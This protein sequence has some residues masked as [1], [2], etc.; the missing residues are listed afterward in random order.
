MDIK[1]FLSVLLGG[2]GYF[3]AVGIKDGRT[4]QKLYNTLEAVVGAVDNFSLEGYDTYFGV[5]TFVEGTSRKAENVR[6]VRSLFLDLD[7]G[8]GKPYS[9]QVEALSALRD[10]CREYKI[11][12]P[13]FTVNSGGGI[14][15]YWMLTEPQTRDAWIPIA[16]RLK[17]ACAKFGLLADPV[18]TS[19]VSRILRVPGT[20]NYKFNPPRLASII[21]ATDTVMS[22]ADF[23]AKLPQ[24]LT[25]V[26]PPREFSKTDRDDMQ[27]AL[28]NSNYTKKFSR[29]IIKTGGG[30]GCGHFKK[31]LETPNDVSYP[32]WLHLLS[33]AKHCEE[34]SNAVHLIS[35]G[36]DKYDAVETDKIAA[37]LEAPH[38]CITFEKDNPKGCEGCIHKGKIRSPIKLCMEVK[39]AKPEDNTVTVP[40]TAIYPHEGTYTVEDGDSDH[41]DVLLTPRV[42]TYQIPTYP[43]PYFR[44]ASGG[45]FMRVKD[46]DGNLDEVEIHKSDLYLTQRLRDPMLGPCYLFRHHTK[47]EGIHEFVVPSV[48]LSSKDEFR[49]EMGMND[50]FLLKPDALMHYISRWVA[51]L[52]ATQDEIKV[53]TQFGWTDD[54]KSFVIGD[55]EVFADKIIPNPPGGRTA[56]YFPHFRKKGTLEGWKEVTKFYNK[57]NFEEH[58]YMFGLSFASPLMEFVPNISGAIYHLSSAESGFGKTT[59]QWGGASVWGNHKKLVLKG[60]DTGNSVWNRAEIYKNIVLYIDELSNY[61][62]KDASDFAYAVTDGEQKNRQSNAGQNLERMRGVEWSLLVGTTGNNSLL[63]KMSEHRALPKG[64]AQRVMEARA[65]A[66][67]FTPEEAITAGAL[68]DNLANNYGHAG[69]V[70]MQHVIHNLD[71]VKKLLKTNIDYLIREAGLS[72]QNRFW[73]AKGGAVITG[74][75]IAKHLELIDWD[76]DVLLRWLVRKLRKLKSEMK[77]MDI[78]IGDLVGSFYS[79]NIRSILRIKSSDEKILDPAM[80]TLILPDASPLYR[81]VARHEYDLNK[82]YVLTKPFKDWLVKQGHHYTAIVDLIKTDMNGRTNKIRLGRGTKISLPPQHVLEMSWSYDAYVSLQQDKVDLV[83]VSDSGV[84]DD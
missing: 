72:P 38:L 66:L 8:V 11:P 51:E 17:A 15:V 62:A 34:G 83:S 63:E 78:D 47:R 13:S 76:I 77:D 44:G 5:S 81:L 64:E 25:P 43:F 16:E 19:D 21:R 32:E 27:V 30:V 6:T 69:D 65:R 28:G 56:Q 10:F 57:P 36:Y 24:T 35:Q 50:I 42:K 1:T 39:E 29:L 33:I 59:G 7:C 74:L 18:V 23:D 53:K 54:Y 82:L 48:K 31:A 71:A 2:E 20:Y 49:K 80:E 60:K 46:K 22:I 75:T 41:E 61:P 26:L 84:A 55:R 45:V 4:I 79:E 70:Y 68:N 37:S 40:D 14:H 9:T 58:Q 52:Q 3:C 73:S 67:L 12:K